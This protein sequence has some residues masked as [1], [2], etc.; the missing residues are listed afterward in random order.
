MHGP[1]PNVDEVTSYCR[2]CSHLWRY[3]VRAPASALAAFEVAI[4]GGCATLT[5]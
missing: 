1:I 4:A 3:E 2:G 5:G